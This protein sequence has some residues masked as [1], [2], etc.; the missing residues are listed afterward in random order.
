[1]SVTDKV[2]EGFVD[3]KIL[4]AANKTITEI[5]RIDGWGELKVRIHVIDATNVKIT[6]KL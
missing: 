3:E 5:G 4:K 1:M 6:P 2:D